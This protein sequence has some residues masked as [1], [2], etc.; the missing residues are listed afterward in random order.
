[1]AGHRTLLFVYAIFFLSHFLWRQQSTSFGVCLTHIIRCLPHH[2][3]KEKKNCCQN[4]FWFTLS[5]SRKHDNPLSVTKRNTNVEQPSCHLHTEAAVST[6]PITQ[7]SLV[8]TFYT[9]APVK[10]ESTKRKKTRDVLT[11][12]R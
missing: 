12:H 11:T 2:A 5:T 7:T 10:S 1:M 8:F 3:L 4:I 6:Q 9:I